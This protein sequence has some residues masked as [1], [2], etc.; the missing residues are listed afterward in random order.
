MR[1]G[2]RLEGIFDNLFWGKFEGISF[3][4]GKVAGC[5]ANSD[6]IIKIKPKIVLSGL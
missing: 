4:C 6:F 3:C 1:T 2:K 5:E